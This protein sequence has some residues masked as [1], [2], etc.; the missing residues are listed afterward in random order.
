MINSIIIFVFL[1]S[2]SLYQITSC[3]D[4]SAVRTVLFV[5]N[6]EH[7]SHLSRGALM[8]VMVPVRL[9]EARVLSEGN[10]GGTRSETNR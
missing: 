2:L 10:R 8:A 6:S 4:T 1:L 5:I 9:L 7:F 3:T